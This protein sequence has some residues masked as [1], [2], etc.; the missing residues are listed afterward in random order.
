MASQLGDLYKRIKCAESYVK[1]HLIQPHVEAWNNFKNTKGNEDVVGILEDA[2][3][4]VTA[5]TK[6]MMNAITS[7]PAAWAA[8]ATG[9]ATKGTISGLIRGSA[10]ASDVA[11]DAGY[12]LGK[13]FGDLFGK[14]NTKGYD[15]DN[16]DIIKELNEKEEIE[17]LRREAARLRRR[18]RIEARKKKRIAKLTEE[19]ARSPFI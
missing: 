9:K 12:R 5:P 15:Y 18:A 4:A 14:L 17:V 16:D 3:T 8:K 2:G 6:L 11:S 1:R 13:T 7:H 10:A 19:A